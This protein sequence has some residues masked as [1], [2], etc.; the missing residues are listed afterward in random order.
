ML[1]N[2]RNICV[3]ECRLQILNVRSETT[4]DY[5]RNYVGR[6]ER[7]RTNDLSPR[8]TSEREP[9]EKDKGAKMRGKEMCR[10]VW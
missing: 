2:I 1:M 7:H 10:A 6:I 3:F 4:A 5:H 8:P 9:S